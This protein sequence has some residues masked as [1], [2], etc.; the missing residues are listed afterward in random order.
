MPRLLATVLLILGLSACASLGPRDPLRIDLA[1]LEPLPGQ[2]MEMRFAVKLRVQNPNDQ[3]ISYNGV[4]L[5]LEVNGQ[6]L[7]S[8]VSDVS[9]E[10]PRYGETVISVP[11]TISAFSMFRQAWGMTSNTP[12]QSLPYELS[13]KLG[14][15]LFGTV[16]FSDTGKLT[17]PPA[18]GAPLTRP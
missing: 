4:A 16:R 5:D 6:P 3:A 13:G 11:V 10:V 17:L 7:A 15:G 9:G 12:R 2:G 8:G 14:G 1:G 18:G